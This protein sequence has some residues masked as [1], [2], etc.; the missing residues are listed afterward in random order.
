MAVGVF[1]F[2]TSFAVLSALCLVQTLQVA[3][4]TDASNAVTVAGSTATNNGLVI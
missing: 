3:T 2:S 1:F 4:V